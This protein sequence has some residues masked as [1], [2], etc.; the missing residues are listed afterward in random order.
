MF[1]RKMGFGIPIHKWF[2][3]ELKEY[4]RETLLSDK[5]LSRNLFRREALEKLLAE[6]CATQ[7]DYGYHIWALITLELWF[8][9]Y[10]D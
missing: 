5:A 7:V 6:H 3:G 2:R 4:A 1:R 9:E 10:F 8:Q